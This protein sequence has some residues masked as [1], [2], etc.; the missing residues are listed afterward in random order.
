MGCI[1]LTSLPESMK[2]RNRTGYHMQGTRSR[3][4]V[5]LAPVIGAE[6]VEMVIRSLARGL[7]WVWDTSSNNAPSFFIF[8]VQRLYATLRVMTDLGLNI[9]SLL[10]ALDL[11][12]IVAGTARNIGHVRSLTP[13]AGEEP[14]SLRAHSWPKQRCFFFS[15]QIFFPEVSPFSN[16]EECWCEECGGLS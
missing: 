2:D 12:Q 1:V 11:A 15:F 5:L 7:S 9:V 16:R 8:Q 10:V 3:S 14:E 4:A 13:V 6:I